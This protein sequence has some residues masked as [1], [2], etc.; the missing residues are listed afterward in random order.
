MP[1]GV[2]PGAPVR[3]EG[4]AGENLAVDVPEGLAPGEAFAVRVQA[5]Q[6]H[7]QEKEE[8]TLAK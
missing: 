2:E 6:S 7:Y 8:V 5:V 3:I 4:P 1:E